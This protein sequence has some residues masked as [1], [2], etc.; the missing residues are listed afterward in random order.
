VTGGSG[1][2]GSHLVDA[3]VNKGHRVTVYDTRPPVG[4]SVET[5]RGSITDLDG[6]QRAFK[7]SDLVFHL[8]AASNINDVF[9]NPVSG[10]R[11]NA[12]GTL[13]VL[14]ACRKE[15]VKE[16]IFAS[17][18]WVYDQCTGPQ[19]FDEG[20]PL[21]PPKHLYTATK[22]AGELYCRTYWD[23]YGL[24]YVILRYGI[25]YGPRGRKGTVIANFAE[26]ALRDEPVVVYGKGENYRYFVYIED[27]VEGNVKALDACAA[28]QVYN[29]DGKE[30][31]TVVRIIE[32]LQGIIGKK[33]KVKF[34]PARP[35]EFV[36]PKISSEK[37]KKE[38]GWS[39][40]V[41]F[42]DGMRKYVAWMAEQFR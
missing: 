39:P 31:I 18:V 3:L 36:P 37:A 16:V 15:D 38:L 21:A 4:Q 14:E 42:E 35:G 22:I 29:L 9:A 19:P 34:E 40:K 41:S 23:L 20:T 25:P 30:P 24:R 33:L 6:L 1:F 7:G 32:T 12:G 8:A 17:T 26:K 10:E 2:I 11:T 27:L 5:H 28:N 13:N